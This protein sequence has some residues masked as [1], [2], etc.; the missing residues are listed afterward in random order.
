MDYGLLGRRFSWRVQH[1]WRGFSIGMANRSLDIGS[2]AGPI[3]TRVGWNG[4]R[5]SHQRGV[6]GALCAVD[7]NVAA[8]RRPQLVHRTIP[9]HIAWVG[10]TRVYPICL[11]QKPI[12][13]KKIK[14]T[15][16]LFFIS[17]WKIEILFSSFFFSIIQWYLRQKSTITSSHPGARGRKNL[18]IK[19][20][21]SRQMALCPSSIAPSHLT[22]K[23][24]KKTCVIFSLCMWGRRLPSTH[25]KNQ[26]KYSFLFSPCKNISLS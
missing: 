23:E 5:L 18:S 22:H 12:N 4:W 16:T 11:N 3:R 25:N 21:L 15:K 14:K 1:T 26:Q 20:F 17:F 24:T 8:P 6:P 9:Y 19:S 13:I 2:A 7:E 10:G